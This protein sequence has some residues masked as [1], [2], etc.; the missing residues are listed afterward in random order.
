MG[1]FGAD[2]MQCDPERCPMNKAYGKVADDASRDD[3]EANGDFRLPATK[4][5]KRSEILALEK[6]ALET[7]YESLSSAP[8]LLG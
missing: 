1:E 6:K 4:E 2:A 8:K 5:I 3:E 7:R